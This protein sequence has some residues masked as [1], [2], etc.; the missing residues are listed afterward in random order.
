[1]SLHGTSAAARTAGPAWKPGVIAFDGNGLNVD[2]AGYLSQHDVVY[3]APPLRIAEAMPFGDATNI[4]SV[5]SLHR[6]DIVGLVSTGAG[7]RFVT[8]N[9]QLLASR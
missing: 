7:Y 9:L 5:T 6:T 3:S 8:S 1:M 4:G 2:Y